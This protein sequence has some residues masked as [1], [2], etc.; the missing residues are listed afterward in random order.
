MIT[1]Y[2]M[3]KGLASC[4][5]MKDYDFVVSSHQMILYRQ[6][7]YLFSLHTKSFQPVSSIKKAVFLEWK[8][9]KTP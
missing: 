8:G 7:I 2:F 6:Q 4:T 9:E 3:V 1:S 5:S